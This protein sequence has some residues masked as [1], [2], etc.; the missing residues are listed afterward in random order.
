M[1]VCGIRESSIVLY[2]VVKILLT[3]SFWKMFVCLF[4]TLNVPLVVVS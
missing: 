2:A 1:D 3:F 4:P